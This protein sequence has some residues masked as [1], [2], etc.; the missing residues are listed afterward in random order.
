MI[1]GLKKP[2]LNEKDQ[3]RKVWFKLEKN[4]NSKWIRFNGLI[5][6]YIAEYCDTTELTYMNTY[7]S[8]SRGLN[9]QL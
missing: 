1:T 3:F 4:E 9:S 8:T 2:N 5:F 7:L 6:F